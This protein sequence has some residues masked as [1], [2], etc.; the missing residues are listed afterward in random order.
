MQKRKIKM[1]DLKTVWS[2]RYRGWDT[3]DRSEMHL[4]RGLREPTPNSIYTLYLTGSWYQ[5]P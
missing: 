5:N 2:A 1:P 4:N 3:N